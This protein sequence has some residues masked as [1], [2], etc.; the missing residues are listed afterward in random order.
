[1]AANHPPL[2]H[3]QLEV[4]RRYDTC[5][6]SNA[7]ELLNLRPRNEGFI[8]GTATCRFPCL[9]AVLGYAVTGRIH[10][11][12]PPVKGRCYFEHTD[13][14]RYLA[15]VPAPQ[16]VVIQDVDSTP[17]SG[18]LVGEAH[19]RIS[20]ALGSVA[21]VT[22]GAV[23]DLPAIEAIGFQLF[24]GNVSVSHGYAH[25][26]DFGSPVQIGGLR[27]SS[28]DLL[29]GDLHGVHLIPLDAAS[30]LER[31]AEEV[32]RGDRDIA[33]LTETKFSMERLEAKLQGRGNI[34]L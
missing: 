6:L 18:A 27:I 21:Y 15:S 1:M 4:L 30:Q 20:Q 12:M 26:V 11:A 25:I 31:A 19:A 34:H 7:I 33:A 9:P 23:R 28:G 10:A 2:S 5:T 16:I 13:W 29:H 14:W 22:N 24:S 17:G 8:T 3:N 32:L